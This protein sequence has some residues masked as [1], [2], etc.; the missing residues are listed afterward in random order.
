MLREVWT[1]ARAGLGGVRRADRS[2]SDFFLRISINI[3]PVRYASHCKRLK[4][5]HGVNQMR[6][7]FRVK[8]RGVEYVP[9]PGAADMGELSDQESAGRME[10]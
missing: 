3:Y 1:C 7:A 6:Y 5:S 10:E 4:L 9:R 8:G 2:I